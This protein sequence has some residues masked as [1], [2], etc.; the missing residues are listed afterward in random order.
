MIER[1]FSWTLI[2][3]I[4]FSVVFGMFVDCCDRILPAFN[5]SLWIKALILLIGNTCSAIGV[6]LMVKGNL[7]VAPT[8]GI[9]VSL[10]KVS[11]KAYSFCKNCFDISMIIITVITC[12]VCGGRFYGIGLGTIFS[13]LY[14]GRAIKMCEKVAVKIA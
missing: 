10:S 4:P 8:D 9:V 7:V 14:V 13:A 5:G 12:L 6:F 11:G 1:R 3:E 2:A